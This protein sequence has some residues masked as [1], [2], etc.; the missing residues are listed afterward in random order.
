MSLDLCVWR[1]YVIPLYKNSQHSQRKL[2]LN[3]PV[4]GPSM[5]KQWC[6]VCG[7]WQS[8][9]LSSNY[10]KLC[11][12][13]FFY[14]AWPLFCL[15][16]NA[17]FFVTFKQWKKPRNVTELC[18]ESELKV[19]PW[20]QESNKIMLGSFTFLNLAQPLYLAQPLFRLYKDACF[21]VTL[22]NDVCWL[23]VTWQHHAKTVTAIVVS[24]SGITPL[25]SPDGSTL[26]HGAGR[27]LL[28]LITLVK[29]YTVSQK[30][31]PL[32]VWQ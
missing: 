9:R 18:L 27:S 11:Y 2:S 19:H 10:V 12:V 1:V 15:C 29:L 8:S 26:Q 25:N 5:P 21:F 20:L 24:G 4:Y 16:R 23:F 3:T 17:C 31:K 32:D 28:C 22:Y 30:S 13:M 14:L 6:C 7:A